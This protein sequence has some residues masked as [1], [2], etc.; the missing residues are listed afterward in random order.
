MNTSLRDL[1]DQSLVLATSEAEVDALNAQFYGAIRYPWPPLCFERLDDPRFWADLLDQ[2]LGRA[3]RP[4]LPREGARVWVAGCGTNQAVITALMFPHAQVVASDLSSGALEV[5]ERNARQLGADN[6]ELRCESIHAAGYVRD[7]DYVVCTG[8]VHHTADPPRA[9]ACLAAALRPAG[10]M[11]LMVYNRYHRTATTAFQKALRALLGD[12]EYAYDQ[13]LALARRFVHHYAGPGSMGA[14]LAQYR[15]V[16][17]AQLADALIQPVEHSYTVGSLER[18]AAEAGLELLA[19]FPNPFDAASGTLHWDVELGDPELQRAYDALPDVRRWQVTNLLLLEDSP[20]LWFYL[21]RRGSP[22]ARRTTRELCELFLQTRFA[23]AR[24]TRRIYMGQSG[25]TYPATPDQALPF[26]V[27]RGKGDA[28]RV[29]EGLDPATP[30]RDTLRRL[31]IATDDLRTVN[32][33]RMRLAS[34]AFPY[35]RAA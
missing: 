10:V 31:G 7:F 27:W 22:V 28:R 32:R 15:G 21:Q 14:S 9:L 23:P 25:G 24:T 33:L 11:Q 1:D 26:P 16:P 4:V 2:D 13:E 20:L 30:M 17:D 5:A 29:F 3:G 6:L 18:M 8:V 34:S 12:G 19:P 35:L